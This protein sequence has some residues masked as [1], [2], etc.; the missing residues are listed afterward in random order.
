M[1]A[2]TASIL[3]LAI[4][5]ANGKQKNVLFLVADDMRPN[6]GLY[7]E[8]NVFG[9][10]PMH[11]PNLDALAKGS[12]VFDRAFDA[13]SL[14]SPSRTSALTSRRPDTTRITRLHKYWRDY[15]GNFTTIPQFFKENGY[16]TVGAGKV[17]HGG[18]S[19]DG[20]DCDYSW[21]GGCPYHSNHDDYDPSPTSWQAVTPEQQAEKELQDV[22]NGK[23]ILNKLREAGKD[24]TDNGKPF[25]VAYGVYKPHTPWVFPERFLD[26]YPEDSI[27][28]PSN[29]YAPTNMPEAAWNA[30]PLFRFFEDTSPEA[31]GIPNLGDANVTI[32]DW[33]VKELRRAYYAS[34]SFADYQLGL[35]LDKVKEMGLEDDTI[36]VFW[37]DHGWHLGENSEWCKLTLFDVGNRVPFMIRIPG[38][39]DEGM[40]SSKLVELLDIFPTLVEAAGFQ[41]LDACP[42]SSHDIELCTQGRSLMPLFDNPMDE[43]WEDTVYWQHPRAWYTPQES[44]V[45]NQMGYT[46]RTKDYRY[47]EYVWIKELE[48]PDYR[49]DFE[50]LAD[51]E[52]LY[53]LNED[54]EENVNRFDDPT[55]QDVKAMLSEKLRAKFKEN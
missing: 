19:S 39:T 32:P 18:P 15:G 43:T 48:Y 25:F 12:L 1:R 54:P 9:Q 28:L 42:E 11:T 8:S 22:L 45:P 10:P 50:R 38:V 55:L 34:T 53:D 14:C 5:L 31:L 40:R 3:F 36:V 41:S 33:K 29:P 13:Q 44:V 46:I 17:F 35:M 47:T 26:Y 16:Y 30:P 20:H 37:G 27:D 4:A 51:H 21:T 23:W 7:E 24:Y 6:L 52:E 49:P 2:T